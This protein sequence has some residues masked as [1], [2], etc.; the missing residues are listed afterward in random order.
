MTSLGSV[1]FD[2]LCNVANRRWATALVPS[3]PKVAQRIGLTL[4]AGLAVVGLVGAVR[5]IVEKPFM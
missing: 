4:G 5:F 3:R 2:V 1:L